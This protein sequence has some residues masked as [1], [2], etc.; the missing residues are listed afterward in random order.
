MAEV[1]P[2]LAEDLARLRSA[3]EWWYGPD[4]PGSKL[5]LEALYRIEAAL[6]DLEHLERGAT[7]LVQVYTSGN[8]LCVRDWLSAERERQARKVVG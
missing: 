1:K 7:L 5:D 2:T 8:G 4:A 3:C 6:A